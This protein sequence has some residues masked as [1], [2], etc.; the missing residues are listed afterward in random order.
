MTPAAPILRVLSLGVGCW[1]L[2][3][4]IVSAQSPRIERTRV[5]VR[6][7][8]D[9]QPG[10][11]DAAV[12]EVRAWQSADL[13]DVRDH[14]LS[15]RRLMYAP[16]ETRLGREIRR[17]APPLSYTPIEVDALSVLAAQTLPRL[18]P[19]QLLRRAAMLHTDIA[20]L[21]PPPAGTNSGGELA[22]Q[23]AFLSDGRPIA[24]GDAAGHWEMARSLLEFVTQDP[25]GQRREPGRDAWVRL[26][27]RA[28]GRALLLAGKLTASHFEHAVRIFPDEADLWF[29]QGSLH[30][31][32]AGPRIQ[33][34][35]RALREFRT[36]VENEEG[37]LRNAESRLRRALTLDGAHTEARV[38]LGRVLIRLGR[39]TDAR[40][41]LTAA[42]AQ[43][44][45][46]QLRYYAVLFFGDA[47]E[48]LGDLSVARQSY[49]EAAALFPRA[50]AP[51]LA[52]S[53]LGVVEGRPREA[54]PLSKAE[55]A[56]D[57]W[58]PYH[59]A[60]GRDAPE[61]FRELRDRL[62]AGDRR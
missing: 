59:S 3:V 36:G 48:A 53:H 43:A 19:N 56:S 2:G 42:V 47:M 4:G 17:V 49:E 44:Q 45:E 5:W 11:V 1:V 31:T 30:E 51:R 6:A 22:Q 41:E 25:S 13:E 15:M 16:L 28:A 52:L 60:A 33:E 20:L 21:A 10:Q 34:A 29:L 27:Y 12:E 35:V 38:R 57:P 54:V 23:T 40:A 61:Q 46:P 18:H 9:H 14:A 26:W 55:D 8:L 62:R 58:W 32:L 24:V 39:Y 7:V 50:Q 37:E